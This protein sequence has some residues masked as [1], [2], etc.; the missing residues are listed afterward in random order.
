MLSASS[1][2]AEENTLSRTNSVLRTLI[3]T[4]WQAH[5]NGVPTT[6]SG[7]LDV[8][9]VELELI[10]QALADTFTDGRRLQA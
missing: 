5:S 6:V 4:L 3:A 8:Y 7:H 10:R 9:I 1:G 2:E